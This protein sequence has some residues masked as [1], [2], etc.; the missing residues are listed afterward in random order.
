MA[1]RRKKRSKKRGKKKSKKKSKKIS[2]TQ[3]YTLRAKALL[4]KKNKKALAVYREVINK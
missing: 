4:K 3:L 2:L 1:A